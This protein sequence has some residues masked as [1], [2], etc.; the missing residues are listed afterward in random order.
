MLNWFKKK[1]LNDHLNQAKEIIV[2]GIIFKIKKIDILDYMKGLKVMH[3]QYD[4]YKR[5]PNNIVDQNFSKIKEHY[6][7]VFLASVVKPQLSLDESDST[8]NVN[9]IFKDWDLANKL[10]EEIMIFTYGKKKFKQ[11]LSHGQS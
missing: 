7:D 6:R 11:Y 3:Q 5:D 8:V 10:Y 9:E 2:D 4:V 1:D